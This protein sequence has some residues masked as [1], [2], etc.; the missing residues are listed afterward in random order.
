[1]I[2]VEESDSEL[3]G[4][5]TCLAAV[6][7]QRVASGMQGYQSNRGQGQDVEQGREFLC[8]ISHIER[9]VITDEGEE[10]TSTIN[11]VTYLIKN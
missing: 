6:L 2:V 4:S 7:M 5:T 9:V 11:R 3:D 8:I 1:M 10:D